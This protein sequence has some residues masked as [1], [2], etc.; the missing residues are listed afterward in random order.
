MLKNIQIESIAKTIKPIDIKEFINKNY[1]DFT[2]ILQESM[3]NDL[4][5]ARV[6]DESYSKLYNANEKLKGGIA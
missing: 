1:D 5:I 4:E 2:K 3:N 6:L